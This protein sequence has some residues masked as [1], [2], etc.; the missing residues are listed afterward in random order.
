MGPKTLKLITGLLQTAPEEVRKPQDRSGP[1]RPAPDPW[2]IPQGE[3]RDQGRGEV[4]S[5]TGVSPLLEPRG[6]RRKQQYH[7]EK[8]GPRELYSEVSGETEVGEHLR[9]V[10]QTQLRVRGEAHLQAEEPGNDP[11]DKGCAFRSG[12]RGDDRQLLLDRFH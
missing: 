4:D 7:T 9:H 5:K 1:C 3:V 2:A 6:H 8:L 10:R 12:L 11:I